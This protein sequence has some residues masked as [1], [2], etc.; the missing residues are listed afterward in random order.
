MAKTPT[1]EESATLLMTALVKQ[2]KLRPEDALPRIM[3]I[4]LAFETVGG[5][6]RDL[7]VATW[8]VAVSKG[9]LRE[10]DEKDGALFLT[11]EG[12]KQG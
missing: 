7:E 11:G 8:G 4:T 1:A 5:H 12:F 3:P 6:R 2:L 10:D 9:W